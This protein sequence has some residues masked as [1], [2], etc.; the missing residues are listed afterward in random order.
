MSK[1]IIPAVLVAFDLIEAV[2]CA[3][4]RDWARSLYWAS[5]GSIT[6]STILMKG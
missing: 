4:Q 2:V 6:L 1:H 5:A 3:C